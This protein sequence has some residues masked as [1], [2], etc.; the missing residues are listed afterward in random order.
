M[1]RQQ[2]STS[3]RQGGLSSDGQ[4]SKKVKKVASSPSNTSDDK[5]N[6]RNWKQWKQQQIH[7]YNTHQFLDSSATVHAGLFG[8]RR[9]PE[10][11]SLW[12]HVVQNE[13]DLKHNSEQEQIATRKAGESGGG[14]IS[15]RHLRRRTGSHKRR[16][17]HR[18]PRGIES[19]NNDAAAD[20]D[21]GIDV[22]SDI[23]PAPE[24]QQHQQKGKA[25]SQMKK[26]C[27][28]AR[29]KP[30]LLKQVH[31]CWWNEQHTQQKGGK[32]EDHNSDK[33]N[34]Y[35]WIPTHLW[36]AK[37][38]HVSSSPIFSWS[39]P[40][41]HSNRGSRAS[42]RLATSK[43]IPKCTIQD[44]SWEID[45]CAIVLRASRNNSSSSSGEQV[46][47]V[48]LSILGRVTDVNL[49]D[50]AITSGQLSVDG[51]IHEIDSFPAGLVGPGTFIFKPINDD[52]TKCE[53]CL[54]SIFLHS[55]IRLKVMSIL[56]TLLN[57][58]DSDS[59]IKLTISTE[60]Y[61]LLRLRGTSSTATLADELSFN[62]IDILPENVNAN[63]IDHGALLRM[64]VQCLSSTDCIQSQ[65]H[66]QSQNQ[67]ILKSHRPN[68][69]HS[70][71]PQNI[72]CSGWDVL[73]HPSICNDLFQT[74]VLKGGACAI[75]LVE[76][77]RAQ[78]E[79]SP[80]LPI[81][82]RDYPDSAEGQSYWEGSSTDWKLIRS[83]I[84]GSWGRN[85]RLLRQSQRESCEGKVSTDEPET[86]EL[87]ST[88]DVSPSNV[89]R[90]H[91][92]RLVSSSSDQSVIVVRGDFGAPFLQLL[93]GCGRLPQMYGSDNTTRQRRRPR[94]PVRSSNLAIHAPPLS[95]D[96]RE[97]H[98]KL[99]QQLK[100]S[101][102]LPALLRCEVFFEGKGSPS[103]G[104]VIYGFTPRDD[105]SNDGS[106]ESLDQESPLG[107]V[108][109]SGFSP[110]RGRSY[111]V[112][113]VSAAMFIDALDG[114][115]HGMIKDKRMFLE[116]AVANRM[117]SHRH[118]R[119][120]ALLSLL[121]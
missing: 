63:E 64:Q 109:A 50:N 18:F 41:V 81:F 16:R 2:P 74:L 75:G 77:A 60:P 25:T 104:D 116:V 72:A 29:R 22:K 94:R 4:S 83:C 24:Q 46:V 15:S 97:R 14:K 103:V 43:T 114:T 44:A 39:V 48:L 33:T 107:L 108:I 110:T 51:L 36:H 96:E 38:F 5:K 73:C 121:L 32:D 8:A 62:W 111:G 79:A 101:L 49:S 78:L 57:N 7:D 40:L 85:N 69:H 45:G 6:N 42:L 70:H 67:I 100:A 59:D 54:L 28:R 47:K 10:I 86:S 61:S 87:V 89:I 35:N 84:E 21:D 115:E 12:R 31:S 119:R 17:R 120:C 118:L 26:M 112:A 53:A 66:M 1:K 71:L 106:L 99:C 30:A 93:H 37:R 58:H 65:N 92:S 76:D 91:W 11:K 98:S 56:T 105:R 13:M 82:P 95:K 68:Y 52:S 55:T 27:R 80:P 34:H 3:Q 113:F 88:C 117:P 90:I 19:N 20:D 102:S 23:A 9:L